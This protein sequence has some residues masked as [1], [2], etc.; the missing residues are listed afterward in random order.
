MKNI[1]G[2]TVVFARGSLSILLLLNAMVGGAQGESEIDSIL[3]GYSLRQKIEL[4]LVPQPVSASAST[5]SEK[6]GFMI[7]R[8][9]APGNKSKLPTQGKWPL[10]DVRQGFWRQPLLPPFPDPLAISSLHNPEDRALLRADLLSHLLPGGFVG[11]LAPANYLF[12]A[13]SV[14]SG[15]KATFDGRQ[16]SAWLF[17]EGG[18]MSVRLPVSPMPDELFAPN[19]SHYIQT[20]RSKELKQIIHWPAASLDSLEAEFAF[21]KRVKYGHLFMTQDY[22]RDFDRLLRAYQAKLLNEEE[23]DLACRSVLKTMDLAKKGPVPPQEPAFIFSELVRRRALEGGIRLFQP[24][25]GLFPLKDL[26]Q[27]SVA[28]VADENMAARSEF[29]QMVNRYQTLTDDPD[30]ANV[31]FWLVD[32][33]TITPGFVNERVTGIRQKF[34]GAR[35]VMFWAGSPS[36]MKLGEMPQGLDALI[37]GSS[38][39]PYVWE[40]MAQAAYSGLEVALCSPEEEWSDDLALSSRQL[41]ATRLKY[42]LPLEIGMHPDSLQRIDQIVMKGISE[43]AM[44]G[45]RVLIACR[46]VVIWDKAYGWHTYN[47]KEA[48]QLDDL[49][50]LASVTKVTATLPSIMKLYDE[51]KW[52]LTDTLSK[53]FL[54]ADTTDKGQIVLKDLL[55]HESGLPSFIPFYL[56]AIDRTKLRGNLFS[57]RYTSLYSIKLDNRIYLNRTVSYRPDVFCNTSDSLFSVPVSKGW[58]M[59]VH[60]LDSIKRQIFSVPL[61]THPQYLYSDLGFMFL[62][63]LVPRISGFLLN[64]YAADNFFRPLGAETTTFLPLQKFPLER[65]VPTEQDNAFR[66]QLLRGWVHDPGAAMMGGVAGHAG[67]FSDAG[68]L[69][70]IMQML[71]NK[72]TYGGVKFLEPE[73]VDLFTHTGNG[74]NRRGLGFDKPDLNDSKKSPASRYASAQSFGHSGFTGTLVW[75][76]PALDLVY[77][78]L[79]NRVYPNQYNKKLIEM[80]IRTRIQDVIYESV[81]WNKGE[82][83]VGLSPLKALSL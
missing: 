27:Y 17:L 52:A 18:E 67:L 42:G 74:E 65:V 8:P 10:L 23:L 47:R 45:A 49:F 69:A 82:E 37:T 75:A 13:F 1:L 36:G 73:T 55:L 29:T 33:D 76:D 44:P 9:D 22:Q 12:D 58:F 40:C 41:S 71:L 78:F 81:I 3:N 63:E 66:K 30:K 68:D 15:K 11:V 70:K 26:S 6:E 50:D 83:A 35:V 77:V 79:S 60:Y 59:N 54:E 2:F 14:D 57:R 53:F 7:Y 20:Q 16:L 5:G 61:N 4:I 48:V 39:W 34:M 21:E 19:Q 46:G 25:A 28:V 38:N 24:D 80:N 64:Q 31:V 51:G 56:N 43:K 72:G 62:G 32:R